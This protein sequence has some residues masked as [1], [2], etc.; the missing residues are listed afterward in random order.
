MD[1]KAGVELEKKL[2]EEKKVK[3][4]EAEAARLAAAALARKNAVVGKG[5]QSL[6]SVTLGLWAFL[7]SFLSFGDLMEVCLGQC[8]CCFFSP[9]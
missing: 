8:S 1:H 2:A 4:A 7:A 5:A 9:R 3:D 6:R